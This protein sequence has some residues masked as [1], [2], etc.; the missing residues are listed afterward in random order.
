M[1]SKTTARNEQG[2]LDLGLDP[3]AKTLMQEVEATKSTSYAS[4]WQT[5]QKPELAESK[6]ETCSPQSSAKREQKPRPI[7]TQN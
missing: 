2:I 5:Q 7:S 6:K 4:N 1:K 3:K